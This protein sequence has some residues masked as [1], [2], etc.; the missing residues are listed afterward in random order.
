MTSTVVRQPA[1]AEL[2]DSHAGVVTIIGGG[3][4][5]ALATRAILRRTT[6]RTT[7]IAPES[8]PGRGVAYGAAEPWHLLNS[9]AGAMSADS[10]DPRHLV[11]WCRERGLLFEA[12]DFLPRVRFGDYLSAQYAATAAEA[13]ARLRHTIAMATSIRADAGGFLV[14]DDHGAEVRAD[15]VVL[16]VGSAPP[17]PPAGISEDALRSVEFVA[18]P[19]A[20][21]ALDAIPADQ[22][23]LLLGTGLT[24]VDVALTLTRDGRSAPVEALSRRGLLPLTHPELPAPAVTLALPSSRTLAPLIRRVRAAVQAG[25]DW[26]A[27]MDAVRAQADRLWTALDQPAQERF[28]RHCHRFWEV[29]RHR[30]APTVAARIADLEDKGLFRVRPGR[31]LS[32][33]PHEDGGLTVHVEGSPPLRYGAVITCTGPGPL[34]AAATPLIA[35]LLADGQVRPGPHGMGLDA[36]PDGRAIDALGRIQPNLWIV[37]PLRRGNLWEATAVPEVRSQV[38]LLTA[39]L[40]APMENQPR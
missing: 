22:P 12:T 16:A 26:T 40:P 11:R 18:D 19:W 39:A 9:R 34:P 20:K 2:S 23:V 29:H 15:H 32:V 1:L 21:G 24:A 3:A 33:V 6:W 38:D 28:L 31:L 4:A 36:D 13:G 17:R 7:L 25:A 8:S 37:G 27:V 35:A 10:A 5:G 14:T 30:M